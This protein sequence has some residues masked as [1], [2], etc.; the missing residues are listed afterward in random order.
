MAITMMYKCDGCD[1]QAEGGQITR[2]FLSFSGRSYGIGQYRIHSDPEEL[3]PK[4]WTAF[5]VVGCT[6][7]PT[8]TKDLT[9]DGN[10]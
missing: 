10:G 9:P 2:D 6:Y 1:A 4:G 7:C 5:C 8:C 3:A